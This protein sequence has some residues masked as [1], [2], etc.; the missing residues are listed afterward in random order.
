MV[1]TL[2]VQFRAKEGKDVEEKIRNKLIEASQTYVK[3]AE[4]VGWYVMQDHVDTRKWA[5]I[6]R[7]ER[8][9]S[10]KIHQANP[11]YAEFFTYMEP[12]TEKTDLF[13]FNELDTSE[14]VHVE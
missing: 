8:E 5:I 13:Q 1:Y 10:L 12:L 2:V 14:P 3:D 4:V 6:E 9:S 7:Y 11:Y